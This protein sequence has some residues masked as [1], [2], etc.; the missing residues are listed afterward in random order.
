MIELAARGKKESCEE[1]GIVLTLPLIQG[2]Q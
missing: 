2:D 1:K